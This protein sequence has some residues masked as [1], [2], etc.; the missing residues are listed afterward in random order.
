MQLSPAARAPPGVKPSMSTA[1]AQAESHSFCVI[2]LAPS[3]FCRSCLGRQDAAAASFRYSGLQFRY[4]DLEPRNR[5]ECCQARACA[6]APYNR[7]WRAQ[8]MRQLAGMLLHG[9]DQHL[10]LLA[11]Q[12]LLWS[13]DTDGCHASTGGVQHR[14]RD[15]AGMGVRLVKL[16]RIAL[17]TSLA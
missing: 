10:P 16:H 17:R 13:D 12:P 5:V 6:H 14:R 15:A 4:Q 7:S 1:A 3:Q 11:L 9:L 2:L 8:T